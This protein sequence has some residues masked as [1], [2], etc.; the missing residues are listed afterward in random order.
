MSSDPKEVN[1]LVP[2]AH[3]LYIA[4]LS[5]YYHCEDWQKWAD[6]I[7]INNK[8]VE[9]WIYEIAFSNTLDDVITVINEE[10][11]NEWI[12]YNEEYSIPSTVIGYYY[13]LYK[14]EKM[15]FDDIIQRIMHDD[16]ISSET[17]LLN[18]KLFCK[19]L[20]DYNYRHDLCAKEK[21]S[22][23]Y[24]QVLGEKAKY[25]LNYIET[26]SAL[27]HSSLTKSS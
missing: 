1:V 23:N 14:L 16:D 6:N 13:L 19:L 21:I 3:Y 5:G 7:I 22:I 2:I 11:K 27:L 20:N 9:W 12:N 4:V 24:F 8:N 18:D 26:Y 10:K 15:N 25:Q 17:T